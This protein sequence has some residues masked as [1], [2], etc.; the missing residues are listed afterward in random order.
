MSPLSILKWD[1]LH[2]SRI[3]RASRLLMFGVLATWLLPAS[4]RAQW[5]V[6][7]LGALPGTTTPN[8]IAYGINDSGQIVGQSSF[9]NGTA[10]V[11]AFY[12]ARKKRLAAAGLE[13]MLSLSCDFP[14]VV[15]PYLESS[16]QEGPAEVDPASLS[17]PGAEPPP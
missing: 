15:S 3:A 12:E 8:S 13:E 11:R 14:E 9:G 1:G 17:G 6:T 4:A 10:G 5:P 2:A 7:G 16:L